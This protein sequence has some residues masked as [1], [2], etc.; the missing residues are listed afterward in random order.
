L[1][2]VGAG[3]LNRWAQF[4]SPQRFYP[5]A[6]RLQAWCGGSGVFFAIVGLVWIGNS[7]RLFLHARANRQARKR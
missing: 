2:L 3:M 1:R 5:P 6:A 4:A 7:N